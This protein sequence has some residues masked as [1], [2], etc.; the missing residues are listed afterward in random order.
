MDPDRAQEKV[1]VALGSNLG[2]REAHLAAALDGLRDS[3][4]IDLIRVS[5]VFETD[6]VGPPPQGPYLNAVAQV[7]SRLAPRELLERLLEIEALQGRTRGHHRDGARTLDLDLLLFGDR[8]IDEQGLE[9][10]HPRLHTRPFVLE[11]LRSLAAETV[12]PVLGET[13]EALAA[14]VHDPDAVRPR[15]E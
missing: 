14:R 4:G 5:P 8:V 7:R 12:H 2:D 11:P 13:I 9:I 15:T 10:P 3:V 6:P 1:Y